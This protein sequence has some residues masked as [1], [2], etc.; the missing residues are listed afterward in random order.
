MAVV[1]LGSSRSKRLDRPL[2]LHRRV[3]E[4]RAAEGPGGEDDPLDAL[5]RM[6]PATFRMPTSATAPAIGSQRPSQRA[7]AALRNE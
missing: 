7:S 1:L 2:E 3:V 5:P 6:P 4:H